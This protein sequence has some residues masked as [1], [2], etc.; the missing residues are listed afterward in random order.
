MSEMKVP[1]GSLVG[2]PNVARSGYRL[3]LVVD[4]EVGKR[5]IATDPFPPDKLES[6]KEILLVRLLGLCYENAWS[7]PSDALWGLEP[8]RTQTVRWAYVQT[9]PNPPW[10]IAGPDTGSIEEFFGA[11]RTCEKLGM[12]GATFMIDLQILLG[13]LKQRRLVTDETGIFERRYRAMLADILPL[14][15]E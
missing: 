14:P 13:H 6:I 7:N 3:G 9:T 2:V 10:V 1:V 5:W 15:S 11:C 8:R 4:Q 12:T